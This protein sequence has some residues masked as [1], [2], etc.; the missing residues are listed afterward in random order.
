MQPYQYYVGSDDLVITYANADNGI[1]ATPELTANGCWFR[2]ETEFLYPALNSFG[3]SLSGRVLTVV[4]T[5]PDLQTDV[6]ATRFSVD[7]DAH[8]TIS[9]DD[10]ELAGLYDFT[11]VQYAAD[12]TTSD[13]AWRIDF[14]VEVINNPCV[15]GLTVLSNQLLITSVEIGQLTSIN[16]DTEF[17]I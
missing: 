13:P 6:Y 11:Y 9:T 3:N 5:Q 8:V 14:K 12:E 17:N 15:A 16:L 1:L 10:E 4:H 7:A 2:S